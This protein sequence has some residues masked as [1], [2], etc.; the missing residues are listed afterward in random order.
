LK[1]AERRATAAQ[2]DQEREVA[3][4]ELQEVFE[5]FAASRDASLP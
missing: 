1:T 3:K 5:A 2:G 4:K